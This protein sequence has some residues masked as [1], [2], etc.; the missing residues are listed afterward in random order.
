MEEAQTLLD[1]CRRFAIQIK[2]DWG[3]TAGLYMVGRSND[4]IYSFWYRFHEKYRPNM[5]A[6]YM[7]RKSGPHHIEN[8]SQLYN[9]HPRDVKPVLW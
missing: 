8:W 3:L 7:V 6:I 5:G 1:T 4:Q 2:S 9:P